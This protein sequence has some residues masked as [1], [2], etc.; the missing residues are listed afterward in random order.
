MK[1][2]SNEPSLSRV[3]GFFQHCLRQRQS[4]ERSRFSA[5]QHPMIDR[6]ISPRLGTRFFLGAFAL[7]A[8]IVLM[9]MAAPAQSWPRCITGCT[10]NDVELAEVTAVVLG[11]CTPGGSVETNLWVSLYF[12]RNKTYCV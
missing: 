10:A 5:T 4:E 7:L 8:L 3:G 6:T 1:M 2:R 9:A 12:N 11:S